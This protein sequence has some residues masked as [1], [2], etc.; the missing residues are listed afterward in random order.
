MERTLMTVTTPSPASLDDAALPPIVAPE[1]LDR[2][3]RAG[4]PTTIIDVRAPA[5]VEAVHIPGSYNV[6]LDQIAEHRDEFHGV[7]E[8]IVLVCRSGMRARQAEALLQAADVPRL[9]VLDGGVLA[10][11]RAGLD[12]ARGRQVWS[13]E[14]QVRAIAGA[15]VLTGALGSLLL[16]QPLVYLAMLVGAGLLVAGLTDTCAMGQI[17]L[18]LP[19]NRQAS[20]D[21]ASV[22][23]RLTHRS[24][25]TIR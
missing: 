11:D 1:Q 16:W 19:Y 7:G 6:P 24:D 13:L 23:A 17:L 3:R 9:H 5:E 20:C 25:R 8:P 2:F 10:W 21:V 4:H 22:L 18:R 12:V 15:L 14:R